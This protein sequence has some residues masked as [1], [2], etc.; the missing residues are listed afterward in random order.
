MAALVL[1][2]LVPAVGVLWFMT[3]AMRNE[4]F[5]VQERLVEV[6]HTHL[7]ALQPLRTQPLHRLCDALL[8]PR[9]PDRSVQPRQPEACGKRRPEWQARARFNLPARK[10]KPGRRDQRQ[11]GRPQQHRW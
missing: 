2:A 7:T 3:V 6:Y 1:V 9:S 5:A 8:K 11:G 4:R 10:H